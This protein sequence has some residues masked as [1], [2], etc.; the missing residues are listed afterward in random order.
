MNMRRAKIG[1]MPYE[2]RNSVRRRTPACFLKPALMSLALAELMPFISA[3]FSGCISRTSRDLSPKRSTMSAAVAGPTPRT[4]PP[5]RYSYMASA[6]VGSIR[7]HCSILN[8]LPCWAWVIHEPSADI[9][10]PGATYG[11]QPTAVVFSPLS[12][13]I[14]TTP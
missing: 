13:S 9:I 10:S 12:S 5:A 14:F 6:E 11:R 1:W 4:V 3:S 7:L 8:C 2:H